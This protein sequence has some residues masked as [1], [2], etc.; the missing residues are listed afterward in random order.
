[1]Y[2]PFRD[3]ISLR[4]AMNRLLEDSLIAPR[5]RQPGRSRGGGTLPIDMWETPENLM[6]RTWMPGARLDADDVD[7]QLHGQVLTIRVHFPGVADEEAET[8]TRGGLRWYVH[9]LPR[10]DYSRTVELPVPV[11]AD[12]V[13]TNTGQGILQLTLPKAAAAR[14]RKIN[15]KG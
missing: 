11:D 12:N 13:K 15:I 3:T 7:V 5:G 8:E 1:M 10:G 6:V 2:D 9:E 14:S 4:D